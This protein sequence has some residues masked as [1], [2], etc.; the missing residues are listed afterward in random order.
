MFQGLSA[1]LSFLLL[2]IIMRKREN[3]RERNILWYRGH[4]SY[5]IWNPVKKREKSSGN[6]GKMHKN[7]EKNLN[8][9]VLFMEFV[10]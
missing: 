8:I 1:Q 7:N 2:P 9:Y 6:V 5:K 4:D 3:V 10:I